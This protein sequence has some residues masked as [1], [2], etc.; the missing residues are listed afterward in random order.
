MEPIRH[1]ATMK[2]R[3]DA[4][5]GL[6]T[7]GQGNVIP[8]EQRTPEDRA[9]ALGESVKDPDGDAAAP[10]SMPKGAGG[11][12]HSANAGDQAGQQGGTQGGGKDRA[13]V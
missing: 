8:L 3:P 12:E 2:P 5:P 7:D 9:A 13:A 6:E 10:A 4:P 11:G 1:R